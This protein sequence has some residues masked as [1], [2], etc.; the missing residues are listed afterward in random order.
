MN[1]SAYVGPVSP[2]NSSPM[3][4]GP[5]PGLHYLPPMPSP[6]YMGPNPAMLHPNHV[7]VNGNNANGQMAHQ[8]NGTRRVSSASTPSDVFAGPLTPGTQFPPGS[9]LSVPM[10]LGHPS[11]IDNQ[12][13]RSG[14]SSGMSAER[15]VS[16]Q[17]TVL[18]KKPIHGNDDSDTS[19]AE[20]AAFAG[21][22]KV[23]PGLGVGLV[24]ESDTAISGAASPSPVSSKH[25]N[26]SLSPSPSMDRT[27]SRE[28]K[29]SVSA[30]SSPTQ[31]SRDSPISATD[32]HRAL[33]QAVHDDIEAGRHKAVDDIKPKT[34]HTSISHGLIRPRSKPASIHG[35]AEQDQAI[36]A[37]NSHAKIPH[38]NGNGKDHEPD[39]STSSPELA[40]I[41]YY[42]SMSWSKEENEER[43]AKHEA[44]Q[45]A[46]AQKKREEKAK[47]RS[48][49][50]LTVAAE[51]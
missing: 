16:I 43:R 31:T 2:M 5:S 18:R 47:A 38:T 41:P 14:S 29:C 12:R 9:P 4:M 3:M 1:P 35:D 32:I 42:P 49:K 22:D 50:T 11:D 6:Q 17:S 30:P 8:F 23:N 7:F 26:F 37:Q 20:C 15:R 34:L 10:G 45:E 44:E 33:I 21:D 39:S 48:D 51:A 28:S 24:E 36:P 46:V 19:A 25:S 27:L 13:M 40:H